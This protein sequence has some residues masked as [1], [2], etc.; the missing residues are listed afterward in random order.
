[1]EVLHPYAAAANDELSLQIGDRVD[2]H[3]KNEDGWFE[4]SLHGVRGLF[5]GNYVQSIVR[6]WNVQVF[7]MEFMI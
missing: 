6:G 4:G 1:M 2:V 7:S 3:I 5:P